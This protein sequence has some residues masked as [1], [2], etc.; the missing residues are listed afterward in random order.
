VAQHRRELSDRLV[1][2]PATLR[3]LLEA[4]D[5]MREWVPDL[6]V[7]D[8]GIPARDGYSLPRTMRQTAA[9]ARIPAIALT[10]YATRDDRLRILAAGFQLHLTKPGDAEELVANVVKVATMPGKR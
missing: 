3:A 10:A 2:A 6:V 5:V 4:L 7:S 9:F 8:I 1:Y